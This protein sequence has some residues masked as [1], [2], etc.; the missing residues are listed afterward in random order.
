MSNEKIALGMALILAA[1]ILGIFWLANYT[2]N[3]RYPTIETAPQET[4]TPQITHTG[5]GYS[6]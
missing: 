3:Y 4:Q 1:L 2:N 5:Y 6:K